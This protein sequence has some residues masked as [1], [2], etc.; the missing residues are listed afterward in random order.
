MEP[1]Y[2]DFRL[3]L[4]KTT[5]DMQRFRQ[6]MVNL[7]MATD[8]MDPDLKKLRDKR[9]S[10]AFDENAR[11][12]E[13][14]LRIQVNRKATIVLEHLIAAS[15][16]RT[17]RIVANVGFVEPPHSHCRRVVQVAHTM[18]HWHI[19]RKWNEC[20]FVEMWRAYQQGR[21][22]KNPCET[23]YQGELGFFDFYIIPLAK[24]L[25]NCGVFGVSSDEYLN[26][27]QKNRAEWELRGHEIVAGL[28]DKYGA[29]E[30]TESVVAKTHTA[31]KETED[32]ESSVAVHYDLGDAKEPATKILIGEL[33]ETAHCGILESAEAAT[34]TAPVVNGA[35]KANRT[36]H[37]LTY[38]SRH[39][40]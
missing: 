12:G 40:I 30:E 1:E 26:Y 38:T 3:V 33:G 8:I 39:F 28:V 29:R 25:K 27:A 4:C 20:L 18:Q 23:W 7:V 36:H 24:K 17:G 9:W 2:A 6:I 13:E 35:D 14:E 37:G 16:V 10:K 22:D 15:D 32:V 21:S 31:I 11:P 5:A 19:Y 34:A